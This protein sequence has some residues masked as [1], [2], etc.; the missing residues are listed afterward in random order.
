MTA[1]QG[2]HEPCM[3]GRHL[4]QSVPLPAA[5]AATAGCARQCREV[6]RLINPEHLVEIDVEA[7]VAGES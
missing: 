2:T 7:V 5:V 4:V 1:V 3:A 6:R